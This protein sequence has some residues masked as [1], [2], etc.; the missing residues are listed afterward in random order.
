[1]PKCIGGDGECTFRDTTFILGT[2]CQ[3][4]N[5]RCVRC[6]NFG[7]VPGVGC[8]QNLAVDEDEFRKRTVGEANGDRLGNGAFAQDQVRAGLGNSERIRHNHDFVVR[9]AIRPTAYPIEN[10]PSWGWFTMVTTARMEQNESY[11]H[12]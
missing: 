1:M 5:Y 8:Q 3:G 6:D 7:L 11:C 9:E 12:E 10:R 4:A 2:P